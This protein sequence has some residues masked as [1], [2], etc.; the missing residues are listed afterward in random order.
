MNARKFNLRIPHAARHTPWIKP[1]HQG[2][3][4]FSTPSPQPGLYVIRTARGK[5][6]YVGYSQSNVKKTAYR[7]FQHWQER[8]HQH[9]TYEK[10]THRIRFILG[11]P[12]NRLHAYEQALIRRLQ[13]VDNGIRYNGQY[14]ASTITD[15]DI[16]I[17]L[18]REDDDLPF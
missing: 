6:T 5:V 1:Y 14:A 9:A 15:N 10:D 3:P 4:A 7:H 13:P 2:K 8:G 16:D 18:G 17:L 12:A 11:I